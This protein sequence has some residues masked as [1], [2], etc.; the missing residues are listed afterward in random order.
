MTTRPLRAA[1]AANLTF[2]TFSALALVIA[3][4]AIGQAMGAFPHWL[5][6]SLGFGLLG[7]AGLIMF[8]LV[9]LRPGW[10]LLISGLDLLWVVSTLPLIA[11]PG[12]LT[13][14]GRVAVALVAAVV[15]L[16]GIL[17][18]RGIRASLSPGHGGDNTYLHCVRLQSRATP[19]DLWEAVRDLGAISR[20]STG[21]RSSRLEGDV[22][23]APGAARVCTNF[24]GQ[25]WAEEVVSLDDSERELVLRFR[26]EAE[27]F[28]FPF[29]AMV[30]GWVVKPAADGTSTVEIWW[31]V[32]P[33]MRRMGWLLLALMTIPLDRDIRRIVAAME[34]GG[35]DQVNARGRRLPALGY[36]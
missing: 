4:P 24:Q 28:P 3:G 8:A 25:I 12:L 33:R 20:Y 34:A 26:T 7:F 30:G 22:D 15:G 16:F 27:D 29:Q 21:L 2:S 14:E 6:T 10:A 35:S 9:R 32:R 31:S 23:A 17:Q 18:L 5:M 13:L 19:D 11:V 36:C 1:L